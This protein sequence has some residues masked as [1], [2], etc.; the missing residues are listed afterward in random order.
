MQAGTLVKFLTKDFDCIGK[1]LAGVLCRGCHSTGH[2]LQG[3]RLFADSDPKTL[4][5]TLLVLGTACLWPG[6]L[7]RAVGYRFGSV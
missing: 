3:F 4:K 5:S 7:C 1:D 2:G 6:W